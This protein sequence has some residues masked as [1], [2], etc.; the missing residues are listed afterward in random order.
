[1]T[2]DAHGR[3]SAVIEDFRR[4]VVTRS[5]DAKGSYATLECGHKTRL[6]VTSLETHRWCNSCANRSP[7]R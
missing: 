5:A 2:T 7:Y 3:Q 4:K 1:M 6:R